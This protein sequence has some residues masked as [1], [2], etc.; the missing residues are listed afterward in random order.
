MEKT[1]FDLP[2]EDVLY[3]R[4]LIH[5]NIHDLLN[6]T[7]INKSVTNVIRNYFKQLKEMD[8]SINYTEPISE[9]I[10][11]I[12]HENCTNLRVLNFNG[13]RWITN[14]HLRSLIAR[15]INLEKISLANCLQ[16]TLEGVEPIIN[17]KN[18]THLHLA[19]CKLADNHFLELLFK[20]N[21]NL[22]YLNLSGINNEFNEE[23]ENVIKKKKFIYEHLKSINH[24]QIIS[25]GFFHE[26]IKYYSL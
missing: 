26:E 7:L 11:T 22:N 2:I 1:L 8:F 21:K 3:T 13:C 20:N 19:H 15:N 17:C 16:I 6:L 23:V 24:Q 18:L 25:C 10:F 14:T 9:D 4:I 5:L 12:L